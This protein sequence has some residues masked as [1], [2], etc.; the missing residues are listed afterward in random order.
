MVTASR[1]AWLSHAHVECRV[2]GREWWRYARPFLAHDPRLFRIIASG[3]A[4]G[5]TFR[6][7]LPAD[8]SWAVLDDYTLR[9]VGE[10]VAPGPRTVSAEDADA[11]VA[12]GDAE[13]WRTREPWARITDPVNE[14]PTTLSLDD[15][16][17]CLSAFRAE[18]DEPAPATYRALVA[19]IRE[20]EGTYEVRV[21]LWF[22]RLSLLALD[23]SRR[24]GDGALAAREV[25]DVVPAAVQARGARAPFAAWSAPGVAACPCGASV[26]V[27]RR[28]AGSPAAPARASRYGPAT[29]TGRCPR[30]GS[31][32]H[33]PRAAR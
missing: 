4:G 27:G 10:Y 17:A 19:M 28:R 13:R 2:P 3:E 23:A 33:L 8:V 1:M 32:L 9:V 29:L 18:H 12:A 6:A 25:K 15:L 26:R 14:Y 20:L 22:E 21:L 16:A 24:D 31:E 30:C 11:W 5:R 7:E